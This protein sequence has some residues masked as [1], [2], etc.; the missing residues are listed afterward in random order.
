MANH[1]LKLWNVQG[2]TS[3]GHG[4]MRLAFGFRF[5]SMRACAILTLICIVSTPAFADGKI[6]ISYSISYLGVTV[7]SADWQ[8]SLVTDRYD[9]EASAQ[10]KGLMSA[11]VDGRGS[12]HVRGILSNGR[13]IPGEFEAHVATSDETDTIRMTLQNGAVRQL[14]AL[15]PFPPIPERVPLTAALLQGV[16]DP[17][18]A[19]LIPGDTVGGNVGDQCRRTLPVFDGRRRYDVG[20]SFKETREVSIPGDAAAQT[21]VCRLLLTPLAGHQLKSPILHYLVK[22]Q[23]IEVSLKP[24]GEAHILV[25]VGAAI[26]MLVGTLHVEPQHISIEM[27]DLASGASSATR[28]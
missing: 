5:S 27:S 3:G 13:A 9:I 24:I 14:V 12:G 17:L 18:S 25:P 15:P 10:I 16:V 1:I 11:L 4:V 23:E 2:A 21:L 22:G 28:R 6:T 26:P 19:S 8:L 7:G 20:L